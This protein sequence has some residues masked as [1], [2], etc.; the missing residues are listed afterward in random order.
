MS[1]KMEECRELSELCRNQL[2]ELELL[3]TELAQARDQNKANEAELVKLQAEMFANHTE[4][5]TMKLELM[6]SVVRRSDPVDVLLESQLSTEELGNELTRDKDRM[7]AQGTDVGRLHDETSAGHDLSLLSLEE[8]G[9]HRP[10]KESIIEASVLEVADGLSRAESVEERVS[11]NEEM[12]SCVYDVVECTRP[13]Y[14]ITS[15][16]DLGDRDVSEAMKCWTQFTDFLTNINIELEQTTLLTRQYLTADPEQPLSDTHSTVPAQQP[17][18]LGRSGASL[19]PFSLLATMS[20]NM[21]T[22]RQRIEHHKCMSSSE[23]P[24]NVADLRTELS[25]QHRSLEEQKQELESARLEIETGALR[26]EKLKA[27]SIAKIKEMS[28]KHQSAV[29]QKDEELAELRSKTEEQK[30]KIVGLAEKLE[31]L[32]KDLNDA[33]EQ[34]LTAGNRVEE[35]ETLLADKNAQIVAVLEEVDEKDSSANVDT[36]VESLVPLASVENLSLDKIQRTGNVDSSSLPRTGNN[37][38]VESETSMTVPDADVLKSILLNTGRIL[39]DIL[40]LGDGSQSWS[41]S[42]EEDFSYLQLQAERCRETMADLM[43]TSELKETQLQ[44]LTGELDGKKVTANKYAAAAKKLKQ[45]VDKYKKDLSDVSDQL[46]RSQE[47]SVELSSQLSILQER[48]SQKDDEMK[49]LQISLDAMTESGHERVTSDQ[50][51]IANLKEVNAKLEAELSLRVKGIEELKSEVEIRRETDLQLNQANDDLQQLLREKDEQLYR[52]SADS[53]ANLVKLRQTEEMVRQKDEQLS[54]LAAAAEVKVAQLSDLQQLLKQKDEELSA[55]AAESDASKARLVHL[56]QTLEAQTSQLDSMFTANQE[57]KN[58]LNFNDKETG[59]LMES[60]S[61][62][63]Q[64]LVSDLG[65]LQDKLNEK[66]SELDRAVAENRELMRRVNEKDDEISRLSNDAVMLKQEVEGLRNELEKQSEDLKRNLDE[67]ASL[68]SV[69]ESDVSTLQ[70]SRDHLSALQKEL[71]EK[72]AHDVELQHKSCEMEAKLHSVYEELN[73]AHLQAEKLHSETENLNAAIRDKDEQLNSLMDQLHSKED[74]VK[75]YETLTR[76]LQQQLRE[77]STRLCSLESDREQS[78]TYQ[79]RLTESLEQKDRDLQALKANNAKLTIQL[80]ATSSVQERADKDTETEKDE[81]TSSSNVTMAT[82]SVQTIDLTNTTD[83]M[84]DVLAQNLELTEL[85]R[86]MSAEITT[87]RN[88]LADL[89][90]ENCTLRNVSQKLDLLSAKNSSGFVGTTHSTEV[91]AELPTCRLAELGP[92][93]VDPVTERTQGNPADLELPVSDEL[94]H[95]KEKCSK[96][97]SSHARLKDELL[98]ERQNAS[99][100]MSIERLKQGLEEENEKNLAQIEA[101]TASKKKMLA[102]L[103]ELKAS[104]DSLTDQVENLKCQLETKSADM[105]RKELEI[106]RLTGCLT[107]LE[108]EKQSVE[109]ELKVTVSSLR[110]ELVMVGRKHEDDMGRRLADLRADAEAEKCSLEQQIASFHDEL[111]GKVV[112]YESQLTTLKSEKNSLET[113]LDQAKNDFVSC[114]EGLKQKLADFQTLHDALMSDT[115]SYQELLEQKTADNTGLEELLRTRSRTVEELQDEMKMLR[116]KLSEA[117]RQKEEF[118]MK[119]LGLSEQQTSLEDTTENLE[120]V[121]CEL[122][123]TRKEN[124]ALKEE[125]DGLNWKIGDLSELEQELTELQAEMFAVQS[126]NGMLKK[127]LSFV[128]KEASER[129]GTEDDCRRL[130]EKLELEKQKLTDDVERLEAQVNTLQVQLDHQPYP[131]EGKDEEFRRVEE[132]L[133]DTENELEKLMERYSILEAENMSLKGSD[134]G[135]LIAGHLEQIVEH[136]LVSAADD[137]RLRGSD[138]IVRNLQIELDEVKQRHLAVE[139]DNTRLQSLIENMKADNE[140]LHQKVA[141]CRAGSPRPQSIQTARRQKGPDR[142]TWHTHQLPVNINFYVV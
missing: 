4:L 140:L 84:S 61:T 70:E 60:H 56:E 52:L 29:D 76:D 117:R 142:T 64:Q 95:L 77:V 46:I 37:D 130:V 36:S 21:Q 62:T 103:K 20:E 65:Q 34:F 101:L 38:D 8:S 138:E 3:R 47:Q 118:E 44:A 113:S 9:D 72:C 13:R 40:S 54:E 25:E 98:A 116:L 66:T 119:Y 109:G 39:G 57:L 134:E 11:L 6:E 51:Q 24:E 35:L 106:Q 1:E 127:R 79:Q 55:L 2:G 124:A 111:H 94:L 105:L 7:E 45:Q 96:L 100:F 74:E 17:D 123:S 135:R 15:S 53:E 81:S 126:E 114:E 30:L 110:E 50:E 92:V 85:N 91:G 12:A 23:F 120:Q 18:L 131:V 128:E 71:D 43:R 68:S 26:F 14:H 31:A 89:E 102:K 133:K 48:C 78:T 19:L 132:R 42:G 99:R 32:G 75:N 141:A 63:M 137:S 33:R 22:I 125:I 82:A 86:Q 115:E 49:Q 139:S 87:V 90:V 80:E 69:H 16:T 104:N 59:E 108:E 112:E 5:T 121:K 58:L 73:S 136:R 28:E 107:V 27:K 83:E 10:E 97:E 41:V 129:S 93:E 67:L 88:R 122:E